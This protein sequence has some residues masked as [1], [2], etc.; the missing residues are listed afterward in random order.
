MATEYTG[1]RA[2]EFVD[3]QEILS[4]IRQAIQ[5]KNTSHVFYITAFG[6]MGKTRL[7]REV[8]LRCRHDREWAVHGMRLLAA[9]DVV[10]LY[11]VQT[12]SLEGLARAIRAVL[13]P[14]PGYFSSYERKLSRFERDKYNLA[15]MLRELSTI[16]D[17]VAKSFL[18]DLNRLAETHRVVLALDTAEKLLYETD[19]VQRVLGLAEEGIA[20]LPWLLH[21]FLP[22]L[23][24]TVVIITGR[25]Q[26][27]RL[28]DDLRQTLP[29]RLTEHEL[30]EFAKDD[31][32]AY[33]EAVAQAARRSGQIEAAERIESIPTDTREVIWLYTGGRPI[34]LSLV[35]DYLVVADQL[36]LEVKVPLEEAKGKTEEER[37]AI[38]ERIEADLVRA[39]QETG[40][41]ADEAIR[42]LAW[43][44]KGMDAELLACVADIP[45]DDAR[46]ILR[47][48]RDLSF[49]KVRPVDERVFLHDEM[50]DLLQRHVLAHLPEARRHQ[51]Y[52]AILKYYEE[53][54]REA[55]AE[56]KLLQRPG[57]E[58]EEVGRKREPV[59]I[60]RPTPP[61]DLRALADATARLYTLMAEEVYYRLRL[62]PEKGFKT[63]Y[64]YT[65]EGFW[66]NEES[67]DMQLR[68]EM[69]EYLAE[70]EGEEQFDSLRR[71]DVEL[72]AA[73]RWIDRNL[74]RVRYEQALQV[75]DRLRQ[76]Y[77]E[78]LAEEGP[79]T[80][81]Q[82]NWLEGEGL[83]RLS[84]EL[85]RAE[86]LLSSA[87]GTLQTLQ[88]EDDFQDWR[89]DVS[90]ARSLNT[91]GYLYRVLGRFREAIEAYKNALPI[92]RRHGLE[93]EH[94]NTLNNLSWACAEVGDFQAAFRYCR[95]GL[96]LRQ[97]L[98]PRAPVAFSLNTWG[99]ILTRA[100]DPH[101]ARVSCERA[102]ALFRDLEQPRGVGLACTALTEA[103]RRM[104]TS[105]PE[106]YTPEQSADLLH[107]AEEYGKEAVEIFTDAVRERAQ[108][109]D[110]LIELGC[111][112]RE[113]ARI[114]RQY[115][116]PDH[117]DQ[118]A[119]ERLGDEALSRAIREGETEPGLL[120]RVVDAQVNLAW[121]YY[122]RDND[123]RARKELGEVFRR[124]PGQYLIT[125]AQGLPPRDLPLTFYWVQLGKAYLLYGQMAMR[126]FREDKALER[127]QEA[128]RN[129]T[130]S[131]A[132]DELYAADFRDLRR[133]MER[134]YDGLKDLNVKEEFPA[135]YRAVD[136][137]AR[138]YRLPTPTRMHK[139][140]QESFGPIGTS[141]VGAA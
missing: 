140:L 68:N 100:D 82:L 42:N 97:D 32:L 134:I 108:L 7:A 24:N 127:L 124:V 103:L 120:H 77:A 81:A 92:W 46:A 105:T 109:V 125:P 63:Y 114:R 9:E 43:A 41:R 20:V 35:I 88:P 33:F 93:A 104:S 22:H 55:R 21:G 95:D 99:K 13:R 74:R 52:E 115:E 126:E 128:A 2:P 51:V 76:R 8:L 79:L 53:K 72:D 10:D 86:S 57:H 38:Q 132:Y 50:Y 62:D 135:V 18:D 137:T 25:P 116:A 29:D 91:L 73:M 39:L 4:R 47:E 31:A 89:R 54:I 80:N 83:T 61:A 59:P 69:L 94:A 37:K 138:E 123:A 28:R 130:L 101:R 136:E 30:A 78:L 141:A 26:P 70:H 3:R 36:L 64:R 48:L 16:R 71:S 15:G 131:L 27:K 106:L 49:I 67:L 40:R 119:L 113:W 66:A 107:Q 96:D 1:A 44:R 121:L 34:L 112:Y 84:A 65:E 129:Y 11:H 90:V 14:G 118:R 98:G 75:T 23:K 58:K 102:L 110:A 17:E 122:Y 12:H 139:F 85:A 45:V 87:I 60:G 117:H 19:E 6:G 5:D 111:V 56:V 133:G